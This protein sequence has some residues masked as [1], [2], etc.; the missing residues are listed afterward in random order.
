MRRKSRRNIKR[1]FNIIKVFNDA[2]CYIGK[3]IVWIVSMS[4][5]GAKNNKYIKHTGY[6]YFGLMNEIDNLSPRGFEIFCAEMFKAL[7]YKTTLT[8]ISGDYGR[9]I[10]LN[11]DGKTIFVECKHYSKNNSIGSPIVTKLLG[12]I[13]AFGA[14][15]GI[16]V[17]TGYFTKS[18]YEVKEMVDNLELWGYN[19][20]TNI[21]FNLSPMKV[22][23]II[24]KGLNK[25]A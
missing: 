14:D 1:V 4:K 15:G 18:A 23:Q 2:L 13:A 8:P 19:D 22:S 17:S 11:K 16:V 9:D 20:I 6:T 10:I 3:S 7:G 25:V 12:S 21:L 5:K 24:E